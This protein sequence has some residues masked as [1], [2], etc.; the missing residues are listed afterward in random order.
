MCER[1]SVSWSITWSLV[2]DGKIAADPLIADPGF[3][4]KKERECLPQPLPQRLFLHSLSVSPDSDL[5]AVGV[6]ASNAAHVRC[7]QP[8]TAQYG[9]GLDQTDVAGRKGFVAVACEHECTPQLA[10]LQGMA[11]S[12]VSKGCKGVQLDHTLPTRHTRGCDKT[13]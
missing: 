10:L 7:L 12:V 1:K 11:E 9:K 2:K 5:G 3:R 8:E 6:Q 4:N 13:L